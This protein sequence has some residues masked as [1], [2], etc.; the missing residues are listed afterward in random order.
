[1]S[2]E[3]KPVKLRAAW[4]E[5]LPRPGY[6]ASLCPACGGKSG[7]TKTGVNIS[8]QLMRYRACQ[9]CGYGFKTVELLCT[10][11]K[12]VLNYRREATAE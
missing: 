1:M 10:G 8:H 9:E 4:L 6:D 11:D 12:A 3:K 7:V 5:K 2:R